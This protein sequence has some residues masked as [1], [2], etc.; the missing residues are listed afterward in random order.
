[1][2]IVLK[3]CEQLQKAIGAISAFI[4]EGNFRF[5]E[6]GISFKAI[7]PS[8]I[9]L[10]S[11]FIE[12]KFF[13]DFDIEPTFVGVDLSE[14][15]KI[16]QRV[17]PNDKLSI[18]INESEFLIKLDGELTRSFNLPLLDVAEEEINIP[19]PKFDA[20]LQV[21]ARIFKEALKDASLFGNCVVLRIKNSELTIEARGS[22]GNLKTIIK[23]S[24]NISIK[25]IGDVVSK[26]SLSFL[27]NIVKEADLDKKVLIEIKSDAPMRVSYN[28]GEGQIVYHLAHMIL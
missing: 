4:A 1:M 2:A 13:E 25:A 7:D 27:Q 5:N 9:V 23:E 17:L 18:D 10:V 22:Q 26:Y 3:K 28:I 21:N 16:M 19:S 6:Q 11:Y 14:F 15:N 20:T 24:K 8:Q 12:K